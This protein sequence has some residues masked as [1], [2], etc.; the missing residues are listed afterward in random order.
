MSARQ[1]KLVV[2]NWKM[3]GARASTR[4]M[5]PQLAAATAQATTDLAVCVSFPLL[6]TASRLLDGTR[7]LLG[8]QDVSDH[9]RGAYTGQV[10]ASMLR[11]FDCRYVI[12]GHS[13]RRVHQQESDDLVARKAR[14]ALG[15]GLIPIFCIGESAAERDNDQTE[16][17]VLRQLEP[18]LEVLHGDSTS[19]C[20]IAYEPVWAIGTGRSATAEQA[21]A[22]HALIRKRLA[23]ASP[24]TADATFIL[25]GGSVTPTTARALFAQD[26]IDGALVGGASLVV[27][28]FATIAAGGR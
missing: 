14:A 21:Q 3:N 25:Y 23:A 18:L 6:E 16:N 27:A 17:V 22:V 13:E 1:R 26:D 24:Q 12:V 15:R 11:D 8:A 5:L 19:R 4:E 9:E 2:G 20:V 28:D 7:I 10:S